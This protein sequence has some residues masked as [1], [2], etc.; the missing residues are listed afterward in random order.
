MMP[1]ALT[2]IFGCSLTVVVVTMCLTLDIII[3]NMNVITLFYLS[4]L[5]LLLEAV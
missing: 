1:C 2:G 3:A 5:K 4:N